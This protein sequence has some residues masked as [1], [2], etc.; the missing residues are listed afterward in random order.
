MTVSQTL[1]LTDNALTATDFDAVLRDP[2]FAFVQAS[3]SLAVGCSGGPDSMALTYCLAQ[4]A[5]N[6]QKK[7]HVLIVD[8]GLRPDSAEEAQKVLADVSKFPAVTAHILNWC[9]DKPDTKIQETA[10]GAR[11]MLMAQYCADHTISSLFLGHHQDD[12]AETILFRLAGGSGLDGLCGMAK[13]RMYDENLTLCRPFLSVP[14]STLIDICARHNLECVQDPSNTAHK[15]A[16]G[17]MRAVKDVLESE[18][19]TSARL[20][21]TSM[22]LRRAK[23]ALNSIAEK[24][25][26]ES[27]VIHDDKEIS[28]SKKILQS[29]PDE[30]ALRVLVRAITHMRAEKST[31]P[32]M[33][34]IET[35]F[36]Y[37]MD[38]H[39]ADKKPRKKTLGGLIFKSTQSKIIISH[40]AR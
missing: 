22:R 1:P 10:R 37:I 15:Y 9:G 14:K 27:I 36:E 11:Y 29:A 3:D 34:K 7:L 5:Y 16:R 17:R 38:V 26:A 24:L 33:E 39:D 25:Y 8:H 6:Q 20:S 4:W 19:L 31:M 13:T 12:Q 18:G 35:L 30:I 32:R 40:E 23:D 2:E 21:K 28:L